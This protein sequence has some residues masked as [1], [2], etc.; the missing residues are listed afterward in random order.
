MKKKD[1]L[2]PEINL[3]FT[4]DELSLLTPIGSQEIDD[5]DWTTPVI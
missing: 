5:S 3:L 4:D 1:Y 2:E